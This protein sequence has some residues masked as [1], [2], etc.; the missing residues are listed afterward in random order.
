VRSPVPIP[1]PSSDFAW[2]AIP[3]SSWS[4]DYLGMELARLYP[5]T[6]ADSSGDTRACRSPPGRAPTTARENIPSANSASK[7]IARLDRGQYRR[8]HLREGGAARGAELI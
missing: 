6:V 8:L 7:K 2:R 5:Y 4:N 3:R 1:A